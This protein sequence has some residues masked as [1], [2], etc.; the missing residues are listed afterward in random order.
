MQMTLRQVAAIDAAVGS[1]V[2]LYERLKTCCRD[3][4]TLRSGANGRNVLVAILN[5]VSRAW[6]LECLL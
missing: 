2:A 4:W 3:G 6:K 1:E 5:S